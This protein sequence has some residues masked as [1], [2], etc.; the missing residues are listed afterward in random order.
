VVVEPQK[1]AFAVLAGIALQVSAAG[2]EFAIEGSCRDGQPHGGYELRGPGGQVRVVGAFNK[3]KRAGSFLFWSSRGVRI[4][5]LPY[6]EGVLSGT[7]ALWWADGER[8]DEPKRKLE[9]AYV[10]GF[11]SGPKR[12]WYPNG[13]IH[14]EFRYE[15]GMLVEARAYSEAGK[16]LPESEARALA[17][18][19][20]AT[21]EKFYASLD[22]IIRGHLPRCEPASDRLEKA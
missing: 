12:S 22:A 10:G 21:D 15:R 2:Q 4:A 6:D 14:A 1:L 3:G 13:R 18:N 19:D 9:A 8:P 16:P 17:A 7:L 5:Q 20:L 11:L